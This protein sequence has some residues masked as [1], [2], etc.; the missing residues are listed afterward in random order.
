[1]S[2]PTLPAPSSIDVDEEMDRVLRVIQR[3][4]N[5]AAKHSF[6]VAYHVNAEQPLILHTVNSF[7]CLR[8]HS[9]LTQHSLSS[10]DWLS[11]SSNAGFVQR[12]GIHDSLCFHYISITLIK[13]TPD[14]DPPTS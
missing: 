12:F 9:G 6:H 8:Y 7:Y 14:V 13:L 2:M 5:T 3:W 11:F 1:M 4:F 10:S